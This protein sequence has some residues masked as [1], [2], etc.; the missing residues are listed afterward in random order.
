MISVKHLYMAGVVH[1]PRKWSSFVVL[2]AALGHDL[3]LYIW[4]SANPRTEKPVIAVGYHFD[5]LISKYKSWCLPLQRLLTARAYLE[6]RA[7]VKDDAWVFQS[8]SFGGKKTA[9]I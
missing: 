9:P 5:R 3:R 7:C 2:L 6:I 4:S 1:V 8:R